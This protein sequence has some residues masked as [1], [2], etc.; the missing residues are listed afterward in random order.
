M[1]RGRA[2]VVAV[3]VILTLPLGGETAP[4]RRIS[5]IGVLANA[6]DTADSAPFQ[7]FL[8]GLLALGY[9][10]GGNLEIHWRSSEGQAEQ[11]PALARGL[12]QARVDVIVTTSLQPALAAARATRTIPIVFVLAADPV[13]HGLVES[14]AQPGGNVTGVASYMPGEVAEQVL[15]L[16]KEASPAASRLAVLGNP[17]NP[18]NRELIARALPGP[19]ERAGVALLP[20]ELRSASDLEAS[21]TG[22]V[23]QRADAL[24]VLADALTFIHA[25]RIARLA[26]QNGLPA[27][28]A[29]RSAVD[30]GGLMSYGPS[31]REPWGRAAV[32]VDRILKGARPAALPVD[33]P[34][35]FELVVNRKTAT[36]L[37]LTLPESL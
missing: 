10:E 26:T 18:V 7:N 33:Q 36:A 23:R 19:A 15:R 30:A 3:A 2:C 12:V 27:I 35:R 25:P 6:F 22:A 20:L 28:F 11:L 16:L 24:Y 17:G 31:L 21:L 5:S 32:Y 8:G 13:G 4:A 34:A 1:T 9:V 37:G 14:L 29:T